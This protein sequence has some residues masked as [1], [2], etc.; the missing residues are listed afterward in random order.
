MTSSGLDSCD[1]SE[2]WAGRRWPR[3]EAISAVAAVLAVSLTIAT[4][5]FGL[6]SSDSNEPPM[7]VKSPPNPP[8]ETT[9][10]EETPQPPTTP[11]VSPT[12][13]EACVAREDVPGDAD[14]AFEP[15]EQADEAWGPLKGGQTYSGR[16]DTTNDEDWFTFCLADTTQL[17]ARLQLGRDEQGNECLNTLAVLEDETNGEVADVRPYQRPAAYIKYTAEAGRYFL[18]IYD[19]GGTEC[20]WKLRL[21]PPDAVT[22]TYPGD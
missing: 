12:P 17:R 1:V 8:T 9:P 19:L 10:P 18:R 21:T 5:F 22:R 3:W 16:L 15:N 11:P 14:Q 13:P 2:K 6:G 4:V 20:D 7:N